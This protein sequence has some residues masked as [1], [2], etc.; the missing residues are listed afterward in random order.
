MPR[1]PR[2]WFRFYVEAVRDRKLRRQTPAV[3]WLWVVVL[4]VA[5]SSPVPG[6]LML[7]E[8]SAIT[9]DDLADEAAIKLSE[10]TAGL[11]A[12]LRLEML[13]WDEAL[14]TWHV[15]NWNERQFES[16]NTTERT[17]KHRS[18]EQDR[19]V[20]TSAVGTPPET[21]TEKN[22]KTTSPPAP[23]RF[24][25]FWDSYPVRFT[26]SGSGTKGSRKNA[27]DAWK[28]LSEDQRIAAVEALPGY[29]AAA[30]GFPKDAERYL[31]HRAWEGLAGQEEPW[32]GFEVEPV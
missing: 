21:E 18:N 31:K 27:L 2:P 4:A 28:R 11:E 12:F 10:V 1:K 16:D 23:D 17:R 26:P 29:I 13:E 6:Y 30:N 14:Q 19:N 9:K 24:L 25:E 22:K 5:R 7:A 8:G 32:D 15:I 3:R 20:P